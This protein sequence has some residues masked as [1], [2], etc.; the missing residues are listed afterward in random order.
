MYDLASERDT[1]RCVQMEI[2]DYGMYVNEARASVRS[3]LK[4]RREPK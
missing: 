1:C 4:L 3:P 2:V